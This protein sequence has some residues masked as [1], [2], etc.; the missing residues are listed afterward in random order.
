VQ[1]RA[2]CQLAH[3]PLRLLPRQDEGLSAVALADHHGRMKIEF[4]VGHLL[5]VG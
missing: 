1:L 5:G 4:V 3:H 2:A